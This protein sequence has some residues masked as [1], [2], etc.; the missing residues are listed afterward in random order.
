M[1]LLV[2]QVEGYAE[3]LQE[4]EKMFSGAGGHQ[5]GTSTQMEQSLRDAEHTVTQLQEN[6]HALAGKSRARLH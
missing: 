1:L 5:P 6:A 2:R 3:K 4:L